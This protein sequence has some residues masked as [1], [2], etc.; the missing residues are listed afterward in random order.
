MRIKRLL[1]TIQRTFGDGSKIQTRKVEETR[2]LFNSLSLT[3]KR[4][5]EKDIPK[6]QM[7]NLELARLIDQVKDAEDYQ[8]LVEGVKSFHQQGNVFESILID[9]VIAMGFNYGGTVDIFNLYLESAH[10][11]FFPHPKLTGQ[12]ISSLIEKKEG[13]RIFNLTQF[14]STNTFVKLDEE[15][16]KALEATEDLIEEQKREKFRTFAR[17]V[18]ENF[19]FLNN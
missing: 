2:N 12:L 14:L 16:V 4:H 5:E 9:E 8:Y 11:K 6:L 19:E 15:S 1:K 18:R 13:E 7:G 17:R 10:L 3:L